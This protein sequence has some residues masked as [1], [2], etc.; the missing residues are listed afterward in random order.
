MSYLLYTLSFA[1]NVHV[2]IWC[3]AIVET[4]EQPRSSHCNISRIF[5]K[6]RYVSEQCDEKTC[7]NMNRSHIRDFSSSNCDD[8]F[9]HFFLSTYGPLWSKCE[10]VLIC[11]STGHWLG[12]FKLSRNIFSCCLLRKIISFESCSFGH[13]L[14]LKCFGICLHAAHFPSSLSPMGS[15]PRRRSQVR[16]QS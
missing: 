16:C 14:L 5:L 8:Y 13:K 2:S 11:R 6:P 1:L 9:V 12:G 3:N 10:R 4:R 15:I 7:L